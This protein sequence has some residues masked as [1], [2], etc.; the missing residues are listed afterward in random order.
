VNKREQKFLQGRKFSKWSLDKPE[1]DLL[2]EFASLNLERLGMW[3]KDP[4]A[5]TLESR[6]EFMVSQE[7]LIQNRFRKPHL[8]AFKSRVLL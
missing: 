1:Q 8:M 6:P 7:I 5:P 2:R 3:Y 4:T